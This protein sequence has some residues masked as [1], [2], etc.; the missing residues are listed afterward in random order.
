MVTIGRKVFHGKEAKRIGHPLRTEQLLVI[1]RAQLTR[2]QV[3]HI[4]SARDHLIAFSRGVE[5]I[6]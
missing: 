2:P 4:A 3:I 1:K 5:W 6:I